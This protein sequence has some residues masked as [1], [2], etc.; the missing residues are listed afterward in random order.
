MGEGALITTGQRVSEEKPVRTA[1]LGSAGCSPIRPIAVG[2]D[3]SA[4]PIRH[5]RRRKALQVIVPRPGVAAQL[6]IGLVGA[7]DIEGVLVK[8][9]GSGFEG[10]DVEVIDATG[11]VVATARSDFDGFFLFERVAYGR[12]RFRLAEDSAEAVGVE[13]AIDATAEISPEKTVVRLGAIRVRKLTQLASSG[14][15]AS[16]LGSPR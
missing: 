16:T 3:T 10:L 8:D 11:K 6:E 5:W 15:G 2:I 4:W 13:R 14:G 7:G 9:D 12:Y 1:P